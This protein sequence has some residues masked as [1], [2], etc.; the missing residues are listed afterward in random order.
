MLG[1]VMKPSSTNR[2]H[3]RNLF[4]VLN[5]CKINFLGSS[6][7]LMSRGI[8]CTLVEYRNR[9]HVFVFGQDLPILAKIGLVDIG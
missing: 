4:H 9:R 6:G 5:F 3:F 1:H 2:K 7:F 8:R